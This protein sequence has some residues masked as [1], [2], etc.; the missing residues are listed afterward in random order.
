MFSAEANHVPNNT[1]RNEMCLVGPRLFDQL[2]T[3]FVLKHWTVLF[4]F[5]RLGVEILLGLGNQ[6]EAHRQTDSL[7]D[8]QGG[9]KMDPFDERRFGVIVMPTHQVVFIRVRLLLN[10]VVNDHWR[11]RSLHKFLQG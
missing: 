10:G 11:S 3:Q 8:V 1:K 5:L 2:P 7:A 9:Q 6:V 4:F